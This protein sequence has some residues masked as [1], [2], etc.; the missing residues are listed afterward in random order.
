M[1]S[2]I[3]AVDNNYGIGNKNNLLAHIPEDLKMFK[4]ITT[5]GTV[6]MGRKTYESLPVKPLPNRINIVVTSKANNPYGENDI[7]YYNIEEVKTILKAFSFNNNFFVIG[8][9]MIYKELLPYCERVY[10]TKILYDYDDV[11][12]YFPNID[13]MLEWNLTS[14]SEVKE[15]NGIQYKFC[16]YDKCLSE[17]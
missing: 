15:Y 4:D 11:D 1:I 2:A 13:N 5:G 17:A 12:T 10:L 8:G 6:I 9:G 14:E 16:I 3:V 7:S